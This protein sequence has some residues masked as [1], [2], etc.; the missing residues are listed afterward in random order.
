MTYIKI[1]DPNI[2]D[3]NA[4]HNIINVVNQHSDTLNTLTNNFGTSNNTNATSAAYSDA[5][6]RHLF[7]SANQMILYGRD[8]F[9]LNDF[10][11]TTS[12]PTGRLYHKSFTFSE[13]GVTLPPFSSASP[14]VFVTVQTQGTAKGQYNKAFADAIPHVYNVTASGFDVSLF[15]ANSATSIQGVQKIYINWMAIGPKNK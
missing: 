6:S 13:G 14:L 3:L 7:D 15:F 1:S 10:G 4:I 2:I 5:Q 9:D 12:S 8:Y 11:T